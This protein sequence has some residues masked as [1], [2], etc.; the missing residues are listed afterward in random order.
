MRQSRQEE[1]DEDEEKIF[2]TAGT[3]GERGQLF[4]QTCVSHPFGS[5]L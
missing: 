5:R 1:T 3:N 2:D 4:N